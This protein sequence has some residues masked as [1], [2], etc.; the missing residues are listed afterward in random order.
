MS[1]NKWKIYIISKFK[2][3][4][5]KTE[6]RLKCIWDNHEEVN[7]SSIIGQTHSQCAQGDDVIRESIFKSAQNVWIGW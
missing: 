3:T 6:W 4:D 2:K 7:F 5:D 1:N